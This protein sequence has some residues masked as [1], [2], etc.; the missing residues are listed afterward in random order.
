[1]HEISLTGGPELILVAL[2]GK[3]ISRADPFE[4]S[5]R[6]VSLDGGY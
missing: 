1:M 2:L 4:I 6:V 3:T 5:V